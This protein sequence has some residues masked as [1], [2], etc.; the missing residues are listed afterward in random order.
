MDQKTFKIR[1][2]V[3][4]DLW[5]LFGRYSIYHYNWWD[6][7][8]TVYLLTFINADRQFDTEQIIY[9]TNNTNIKPA[10]LS[11][12]STRRSLFKSDMML[13]GGGRSRGLAV[14][15]AGGAGAA[16]RCHL[17]EVRR[18]V[19]T[20]N[21]TWRRKWTDKTFVRITQ[22]MMWF[23]LVKSMIFAANMTY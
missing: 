19:T 13:C 4:S 14:I 1:C 17:L 11:I 3:I 15:V 22:Y 20:R 8:W 5:S 18:V 7:N 16:R 6:Y 23:L 10:C 9:L 2:E 12:Q 21:T